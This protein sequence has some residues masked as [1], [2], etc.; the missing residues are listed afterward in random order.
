MGLHRTFF[1]P[2]TGGDVDTKDAQQNPMGG[3]FT[4]F[5][6]QLPSRRMSETSAKTCRFRKIAMPMGVENHTTR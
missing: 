5:P 6:N 3:I 2:K 1:I 4:P